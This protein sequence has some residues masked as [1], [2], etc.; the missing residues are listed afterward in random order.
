M[1][2]KLKDGDDD[3]MEEINKS[4]FTTVVQSLCGGYSSLTLKGR[5]HYL[6]DS[7]KMPMFTFH[8]FFS[9]F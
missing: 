8:F 5:I 6:T 4:L 2:E 9:T 1:T 7:W 3:G